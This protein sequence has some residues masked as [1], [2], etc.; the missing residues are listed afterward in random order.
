VFKASRHDAY[1]FEHPFE[2]PDR[3]SCPRASALNLL[4]D[5]VFAR[6]LAPT[7][8]I[9]R[10]FQ[11]HCCP[12]WSRCMMGT[13]EAQRPTDQEPR[14]QQRRS[15]RNRSRPPRPIA[16]ET[17]LQSGPGTA[18]SSRSNLDDNGQ[19]KQVRVTFGVSTHG[20][21]SKRIER[22]RHCSTRSIVGT[23]TQRAVISIQSDL[24]QG[25]DDKRQT[26]PSLVPTTHYLQSDHASSKLAARH[27]RACERDSSDSLCRPISH[28][29]LALALGGRATARAEHAGACTRR[30]MLTS[31][32][33]VASIAELEAT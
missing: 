19:C 14:H 27:G 1:C 26:E 11:P 18:P 10:T 23:L 25:G 31:H 29:R 12:A 28:I 4:R 22:R 30:R 15:V 33:H 7:L 9:S 8:S 13:S 32:S 6:A 3:C 21:E 5:R 24:L 17:P 2:P 16:H 20:V